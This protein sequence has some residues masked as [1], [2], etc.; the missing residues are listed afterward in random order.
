MLV[1]RSEDAVV[2]PG[3]VSV[4]EDFDL[5]CGGLA[6]EERNDSLW[7]ASADSASFSPVVSVL[8]GL[9]VIGVL[10]A[11]DNGPLGAELFKFCLELLIVVEL[12]DELVQ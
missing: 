3:P 1:A 11:S 4:V 7:L 5:G 9:P 6:L 10:G 8:V 2:F 12:G